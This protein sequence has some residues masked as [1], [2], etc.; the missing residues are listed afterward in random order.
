MEPPI[1]DTSASLERTVF[2]NDQCI[3]IIDFREEDNLYIIIIIPL[4]R[5]L[6]RKDNAA[7]P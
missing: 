6:S 4:R 2:P 5:G 3:N 1:K 7:G